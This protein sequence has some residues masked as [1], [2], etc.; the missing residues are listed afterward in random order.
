[1]KRLILQQP[2]LHPRHCGIGL[3]LDLGQA[4]FPVIQILAHAGFVVGQL[5]KVMDYNLRRICDLHAESA[6][7]ILDALMDAALIADLRVVLK[8]PATQVLAKA[9]V[10]P[11]AFVSAVVLTRH[12]V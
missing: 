8:E 11:C 7:R 6:N 12:A 4:Q 9:R 1:M 3:F 5:S 2:H 10:V